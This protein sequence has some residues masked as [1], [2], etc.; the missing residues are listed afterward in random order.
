MIGV[1]VGLTG[2]AALQKGGG[3]NLDAF[4]A[5]Q[6]DG[7]YFDTTKTDRFFQENTG[8]TLAD[9]VGEAMGLALSQRAWNGQ[10]LAEVLAA[11][12]EKVANGDFASDTAWT[13]G[14]GWSIAGGVAVHATGNTAGLTQ[15]STLTV[16]RRYRVMFDVVGSTA[17]SIRLETGSAADEKTDNLS[18]NGTKVAYLVA[19]AFVNISFIPFSTFDGSIDN[20][21]IKEVPGKHGIQATGTLKPTRQTTGA[22]FDGADDSWLTSYMAAAGENFIVALV[23]VPASLSGTQFIAGA[24]GASLANACLLGITSAGRVG[25]GVGSKLP[26]TQ[27]GTSDVRGQ[28][29]AVGLSFDGSIVKVFVNDSEEFAGAQSGTATTLVPLRIGAF[30]NNGTA[31]NFFGGAVKKL[32]AGREFLTLGRYQQIRNALLNS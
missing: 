24:T 21:S 2:V 14:A 16:G 6:A 4:M 26:A 31:A 12:T 28:T 30:N 27:E 8:P 7:L 23:D 29:V 5:A 9:D 18:G 11:A 15:P 3:F 20:V 13:K 19:G 32:V 25:A 10:T 1:G 22:K 17:G